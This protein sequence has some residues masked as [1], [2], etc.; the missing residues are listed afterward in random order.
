M[1]FFVKMLMLAAASG[2]VV[3]NSDRVERFY[4]ELVAETQ[5]VASG[6]DMRNI[7]ILLDYTY[8]R[9]GQY[10]AEKD[11]PRWMVE[12]FK[13][14]SRRELVEDSWGNPLLYQTS[15]R[16]KKYRLVSTGPD[17]VEG[18]ADDIVYTGP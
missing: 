18:S 4:D 15:D 6:M 8:A 11:F 10:P 7:A 2:V 14:N 5:M 13:E 1:T 12:N 9:K 3:N 17:A 16:R